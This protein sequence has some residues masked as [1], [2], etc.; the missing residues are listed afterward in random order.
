MLHV[1]HL[2][3]AGCMAFRSLISCWASC[4]LFVNGNAEDAWFK[5]PEVSLNIELLTSFFP[6]IIFPHFMPYHTQSYDVLHYLDSYSLHIQCLASL[7]FCP[8]VI[9]AL[10]YILLLADEWL[11][12][13]NVNIEIYD[14]KLCAMNAI[15]VFLLKDKVDNSHLSLKWEDVPLNMLSRC[16][17]SRTYDLFHHR[18]TLYHHS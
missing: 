5:R 9:W 13:V 6:F 4:H 15:S 3:Q 16:Q 17:V 1:I 14:Q 12:D 8:Y 2:G 10:S 18:Q 11:K 7:I